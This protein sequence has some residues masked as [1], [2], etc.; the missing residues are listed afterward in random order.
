MENKSLANIFFLVDPYN[1]HDGYLG[2]CVCVCV[3]VWKSFSHVQFFVT[4]WSVTFQAPLTM[5][6]SRQN[7][8]WVTIP[9]SRGPSQPWD[10]T[11]VSCTARRFFTIWVTRE[12]QWISWK[13]SNRA[14]HLV[15]V[16]TLKI[17]AVS[18]FQLSDTPG[19]VPDHSLFMDK[20]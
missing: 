3:C 19:H 16:I 7:T 13:S 6:F 15:S 2:V 17:L 8:E 4:P 18:I 11:L 12:A 5:K 9:F 10:R 14:Y 1:K 20:K